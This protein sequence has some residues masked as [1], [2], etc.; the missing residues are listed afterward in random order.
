MQEKKRVSTY[1][2]ILYHIV[3]ATKKRNP[4]LTADRRQ[5]LF[6]YI[7]GII[8]N[9]KSH[10]YRLNGVEDH[11]HI[12]TSLHPSVSLADFVK[13]I[14]VASSV[15][16]QREGL[17][18]EFTRWQEGYG[19]FTLSLREKDRVIEYIKGQEEHHA[20]IS[21]L[22]ELRG[23]LKEAGVEFDERYLA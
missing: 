4:A 17:F 6:R 16:I 11:L 23:L 1:T 19:A 14:K 7:W 12:L 22:D 3:F 8:K 5:D 10:L 18:P 20:R 21:Y 15:W 9:K 2:H 13:D